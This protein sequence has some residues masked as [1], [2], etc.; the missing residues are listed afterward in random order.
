[1][2]SVFAY[3]PF[4]I[5]LLVLLTILTCKIIVQVRYQFLPDAVS[6]AVESQFPGCHKLGF[7]WDGLSG[8]YQIEIADRRDYYQ[9]QVRPNGEIMQLISN[10]EQTFDTEAK[11]SGN[12]T[13]EKSTAVSFQ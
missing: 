10:A 11:A 13:N 1:M 12:N 9:L 7:A 6:D 5:S 3:N 4:T 2:K 8:A